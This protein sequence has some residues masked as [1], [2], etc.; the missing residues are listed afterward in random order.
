MPAG[1][2]IGVPGRDGL[3]AFSGTHFLIPTG[4]SCWEIGT[5]SDIAG[6]ANDD[7]RKRSE[8]PPSGLRPNECTF[9]FV[10]S[11]V[12]HA[13]LAWVESKHADA[14]WADVRAIDAE[15]IAVWLSRFPAIACGIAESLGRQ[16]TGLQTL[17]QYW[18]RKIAQPFKG[19][20]TPQLVIGGRERER[21]ELVNWLREGTGEL[22]LLGETAEDAAMFAAAALRELDALSSGDETAKLL[23]RVLAVSEPQVSE[24]LA[25]LSQ[26]HIVLLVDGCESNALSVDA[27]PRLRF[28][29]P[30]AID[31]RSNISTPSITLGSVRWAQISTAL[32]EL[33]YREEVAQAIASECKGSLQAVLQMIARPERG[34][35]GWATTPA[36]E[37]LAPLI[38]AGKWRASDHADHEVI[39][40]LAGRPY[41]EVKQAIASW[42]GPAKP[43]QRMGGDWIWRARG[44]AWSCLAPAMDADEV[45]R[46]LN[47]TEEVLQ[48]TDPGLQLP[49]D[50]RWLARVRGLAHKFSDSLREGL[51]QSLVL[52]AVN[53]GKVPGINAQVGVDRVVRSLLKE[54]TSPQRWASLAPL[55]PELAEASPDAF[56]DAAEACAGSD[57]CVRELFAESGY[58][59][60]SRHTGLLW[61]LERLAW[62][63]QHLTRVLTVLGRF[64]AV[65]PGGTLSN[66]P[67]SSMRAIL[68]PWMPGTSASVD[69]RLAALRA[70]FLR[71]GSSAW[72]CAVSLLPQEA[73]IGLPSSRPRWRNWA[74]GSGNEVTRSEYW[75]F[76][77]D[78]VLLLLDN[79]GVDCNRWL[80]L[81]SALPRLLR[82]SPKLGE[83]V[84]EAMLHLDGTQLEVHG[85]QKIFETAR[86]LILRERRRSG[87]RGSLTRKQVR[88]LERV[89]IAFAPSGPR[90]RN[91]WLFVQ[92]PEVRERPKQSYQERLRETAERRQKAVREVLHAEGLDGVLNWVSEVTHPEALGFA[93]GQTAALDDMKNELIAFSFHEWQDAAARCRFGWGY[94]QALSAR[95]P[96]S[97]MCETASAIHT[98]FGEVAATAFLRAMP[99]GTQL[100]RVVAEMDSVVSERYWK[101][102]SLHALRL[103]ECEIAVPHLLKANR[104]YKVVDLV[105][106]LV[107]DGKSRLD[108]QPDDFE[109]RLAMLVR[110]AL[111][112]TLDH[113]PSAEVGDPTMLRYEIEELFEFLEG[114]LAEI[115]EVAALEWKWFPFF[116]IDGRRPRA[117]QVMLQADPVLFVD[118]LSLVFR[119]KSEGRE[120]SEKRSDETR[121]K[122]ELAYR[123]LDSWTSLPGLGVSATRNN[124]EPDDG[125]EP[126]RPGW[127]GHVDADGLSEW[128]SKAQTLADACGRLEFCNCK[129]GRQFAYAPADPDGRWPCSAVR[130]LIGGA[131]E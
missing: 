118:L 73:G 58:I 111:E 130:N 46:W 51:S 34:R 131:T 3:V 10:T 100:W 49:P 36:A 1:D 56:I 115:E 76:Q 39:A 8:K 45:Q 102:V 35:L 84:L 125:L 99:F 38:W 74:D 78:L 48:E 98:R 33:G 104:P 123:L 119:S 19:R 31:S 21:Q 107:L 91:R 30:Q 77:Q 18:E 25:T 59:P 93:V 42:S 24:H 69:D 57:D 103:D 122:A 88:H 11:R 82:A 92:Y 17:D 7:Y 66:R 67:I 55:L 52:L 81:L 105:G 97:W 27:L 63:R 53:D 32:T 9:V 37:R 20:V 6:K 126:M 79:A 70:L 22:H 86:D 62:S 41:S 127:D 50:D 47:I 72:T 71:C 90:D 80:S 28:L 85:R 106:S 95:R 75:S 15:D 13:K 120:P 43:I 124:G 64:D 117:L 26:Q 16:I 5:G 40:A 110:T 114:K 129:I 108:G 87:E 109:A 65:D 44:F 113:A 112:V 29:V 54:N 60:S 101:Q 89:P 94:V 83:K 2:Q 12:W 96:C 61:A 128:V 68:L 116:G 121:L 23:G 4:T 14:T